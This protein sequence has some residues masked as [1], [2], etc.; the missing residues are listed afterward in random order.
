MSSPQSFEQQVRGQFEIYRTQ[1]ESQSKTI[2]ELQARIAT[3]ASSPSPLSPTNEF[4][5][6]SKDPKVP[7]VALFNGDPKQSFQFLAHLE[8]FFN[9][10]RIRYS[11][12]LLKSYYLGLRCTGSAATWF[13][14]IVAKPNSAAYLADWDTLV[15]NFRSIFADSTRLQDAERSLLSLKQGKRSLATVVPEFHTL[16]SITG[17]ENKALFPI[18]LDLLNDDVRDELL[19]EPRPEDFNIF[20]SRAITIDRTLH[21]RRIDRARRQ[22]PTNPRP[23][24]H[25][26]TSLLTP[27]AYL[28]RPT[29]TT[30]DCSSPMDL[31]HIQ[32][33]PRRGPLTA[34]ERAHRLSN[35]LCLICGKSGHLRANCP[36]RRQ[37][38]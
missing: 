35:N 14:N 37:D 18:F 15:S 11:D 28:Q 12:P 3:A 7:D 5:E 29:P 23:P 9:L 34:E 38:F 2:A 33:N 16:V 24:P 20:V 21:A 10:Q 36:I 32:T 4:P 17:W 26:P 22:L 8:I 25:P 13:S 6:V 27:S 19:R 1:L 30:P 31:S